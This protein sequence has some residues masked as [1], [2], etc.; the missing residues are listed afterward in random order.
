VTATN[1]YLHYQL[2]CYIIQQIYYQIENVVYFQHRDTPENNPS[3]PFE[4]T[5][6]NLK[7]ICLFL[8]YLQGL[9]VTDRGLNVC[10]RHINRAT[11]MEKVSN[12][13]MIPNVLLSRH[14]NWIALSTWCIFES[15]IWCTN[16]HKPLG[17]DM[18]KLKVNSWLIF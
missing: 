2:S 7:V 15:L 17:F 4:F 13:K 11:K 3:I 16:I 14:F 1:F 12:I 10:F 18:H 6:E 8:L 5:P 9:W